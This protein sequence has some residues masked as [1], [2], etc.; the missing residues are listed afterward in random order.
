M[1]ENHFTSSPITFWILPL[2]YLLV[3]VIQRRQPAR[4]YGTR[5]TIITSYT[6]A[7]VVLVLAPRSVLCWEHYSRTGEEKGL[8]LGVGNHMTRC[9]FL[10]AGGCFVGLALLHFLRGDSIQQAPVPWCRRRVY[11]HTHT[12]AR[13]P[14]PN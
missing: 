13:S 3:Q 14:R 12:H 4:I 8:L 2:L 1:T 7:T 9:S 11:T 10:G 5:S 6:T